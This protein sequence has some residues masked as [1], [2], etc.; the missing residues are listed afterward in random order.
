MADR[1][2]DEE[3]LLGSL[4][5]RR[6]DFRLLL[7]RYEG[8]LFNFLYHYVG[9]RQTAE[10]LFQETFLQVYA[11]MDTF[12]PDG[13]FKPWMYTI[14][15]NLARDAMRK[16]RRRRAFSLD[17]EI[18]PGEEGSLADIVESPAPEPEAV[19]D[20]QE[21]AS[22]ARQLL[23]ELPESLREIVTLYFYNDLKYTEIS[24]VLDLPMGTV[25]SRLYR[26]MRQMASALKRKRGF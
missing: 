5:G 13:R 4:R 22:L 1:N 24:Q 15:A 9:D 14:A 23:E 2:S 7:E 19:L 21:S 12:R 16:R 6:G 10:D 25:K 20:K 8:E 26:A 18:R 17:R 3:L 11:K